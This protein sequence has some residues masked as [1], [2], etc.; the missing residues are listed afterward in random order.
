MKK[1]GF[2]IAEKDGKR[3]IRIWWTSASRRQK[4]NLKGEMVRVALVALA[5][6]VVGLVVLL[7]LQN[8]PPLGELLIKLLFAVFLGKVN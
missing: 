4:E 1:A 3:L 7:A 8:A 2:D 5:I 6:A